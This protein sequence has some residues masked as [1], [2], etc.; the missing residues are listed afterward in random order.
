MKKG[1][2][3]YLKL[4]L[5]NKLALNVHLYL[6]VNRSEL[7]FCAFSLFLCIQCYLCCGPQMQI[8]CVSLCTD[9]L[10]AH[11]QCRFVLSC[12]KSPAIMLHDSVRSLFRG[13]FSPEWV[14]CCISCFTRRWVLMSFLRAAV[15]SP[16]KSLSCQQLIIILAYETQRCDILY[17]F[18]SQ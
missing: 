16:R 5:C 9:C 11:L 10:F 1:T 14:G 12:W 18:F 2:T 13:C 3:K 8:P 7:Y 15:M 6:L 17:C 4:Q